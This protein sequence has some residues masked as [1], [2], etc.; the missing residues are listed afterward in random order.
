MFALLNNA[1]EGETGN[2]LF[3]WVFGTA[4]VSSIRDHWACAW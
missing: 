2:L 4:M 1:G 3:T